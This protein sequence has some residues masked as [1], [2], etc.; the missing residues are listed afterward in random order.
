M[1]SL[2]ES[3]IGSNNAAA[4]SLLK[5]IILNPKGKEDSLNM[6]WKKFDLSFDAGSGEGAWTTSFVNGYPVYEVPIKSKRPPHK[7]ILLIGENYPADIVMPYRKDDELDSRWLKKMYMKKWAEK[8][9]RTLHM[10]ISIEKSY[11]YLNF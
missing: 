8:I 11:I 2:Y 9:S 4:R 10:N 6:L 7:I 1:K 5:D 3:I